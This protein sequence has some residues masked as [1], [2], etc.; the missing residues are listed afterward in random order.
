M[1]EGGVKRQGLPREF[2]LFCFPSSPRPTDAHESLGESLI[3][4]AA[5]PSIESFPL[6]G[7]AP[8]PACGRSGLPL[9]GLP[10]KGSRRV[11]HVASSALGG[12]REDTT[13]F[14]ITFAFLLLVILQ[15]CSLIFISRV[16][17]CSPLSP[18]PSLW[19]LFSLSR[20]LVHIFDVLSPL[21]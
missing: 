11:G 15:I 10:G 7:A 14:A 16:R 12:I 19:R 17:V 2:R 4:S 6:N 3:P 1:H 18:S 21:F 13:P 20:R 8:R 9:A 5:P